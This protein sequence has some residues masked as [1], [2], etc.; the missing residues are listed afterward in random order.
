V[1]Q[2]SA[3]DEDLAEIAI[4]IRPW[5]AGARTPERG[6]DFP[7]SVFSG[8]SSAFR[9]VACAR[10]NLARRRRQNATRRT[11]SARSELAGDSNGTGSG[12]V[13]G[14]GTHGT[15][16][17]TARRAR[18]PRR[19]ALVAL[20][21]RA[22]TRDAPRGSDGRGG[23]VFRGN[24]PSARRAVT[25]GEHAGR[26]GYRYAIEP[27][28]GGGR[29]GFRARASIGSALFRPSAFAGM[30]NR[31]SSFGA[32]VRLARL[33]NRTRVEIQPRTRR[34]EHPT[35]LRPKSSPPDKP[36]VP[37]DH[38]SGVDHNGGGHAMLPTNQ[39]YLVRA[40]RT[41]DRFRVFQTAA[42]AAHD[43]RRRVCTRETID[44]GF[45]FLQMACR[46]FTLDKCATTKHK[47]RAVSDKPKIHSTPTL[48][49][50]VR[51]VR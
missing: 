49:A 38:A 47:R 28:V 45:F 25:Y 33:R 29:A 14:R 42:S 1:T 40:K 27:V 3:G 35:D 39:E 5:D 22:L 4:L 15:S 43:A 50:C 31:F 34:D 19:A 2:G 44:G 17:R 16:R 8:R 11:P 24:A 6:S 12:C 9:K 48:S 21:G 7:D 23:R 26:P 41:I 13:L 20:A 30:A 37:F 18:G 51:G 46:L 10:V 32:N 36:V